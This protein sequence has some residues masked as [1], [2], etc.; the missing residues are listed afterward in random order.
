MHSSTSIKSLEAFQ[1]ASWSAVL[2]NAFKDPV[3]LLQFLQLDADDYLSQL[4]TES[5]F[6]MLVPL[7]YAEKMKKGDWNDPILR[8]VLPLIRENIKTIGFVTDPVGD[9]NAEI[10]PG[11]LQKYQGRVLL[12]VTGACPVHCRYCF[13]REFPYSESIPDKKQWQTTLSNIQKDESINEIIMSGGDPLM[14]SDKRLQKMCADLAKVPHIKTLRFHTRV[15]VFIP[16]RL[17]D[18]FL[19][20]LYNLEL[21]KVMVIH[22]NHANEL[23]DVVGNGLLALRNTGVTLLN[24]SVLL[25]GI[26]DSVEL[27]SAL[28]M[29]L[30]EFQVL[31]YYLHQLD[32][33]QGTAH[34]EVEKTKALELIKTLQNKLPGYLIPRL[35]E[36]ISGKRSK[37]A[38]V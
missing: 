19:N 31:P 13:R 5:N 21:R 1:E 15:P 26:N 28:S 38:I 24:Q 35:V 27:L 36:E 12:L 37:Q 14:L 2:S 8:Q 32:R 16:E 17:T 23:D 34:F 9:L 18:T 22:T 7:S 25:K 30:I 11:L 29:R 20:W 4:Q 3:K 33:I 6:R 10:S